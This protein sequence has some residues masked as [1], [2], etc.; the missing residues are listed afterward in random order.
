MVSCE[1]GKEIKKDVFRLVTS[2]GVSFFS[3]SHARDKTKNIFLYMTHLL[4]ITL[5]QD[6]HCVRVKF[7]THPT[8][9]KNEANFGFVGFLTCLLCTLLQKRCHLKS[10]IYERIMGNV[11]TVNR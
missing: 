5:S 2:V 4:P 9:D 8:F 6:L 3:L 7:Q 11:R 1:L 10:L